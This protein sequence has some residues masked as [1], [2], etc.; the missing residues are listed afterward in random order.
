MP[1]WAAYLVSVILVLLESFFCVFFSSEVLFGFFGDKIFD[2][3]LEIQEVT[4]PDQDESCCKE[5]ALESSLIL[6]QIVVFLV[7]LPLN[8][9][10]SEFNFIFIN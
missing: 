2:K 10:P 6:F 9:I 3:T 4:F 7:T 8:V 5:V 1:E